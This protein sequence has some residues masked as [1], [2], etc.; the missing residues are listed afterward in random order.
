M[1]YEDFGAFMRLAVIPRQQEHP[2][3]IRLDGERTGGK[4]K[5]FGFFRY[6]G[7]EWKVDEDTHY[8][9]LELAYSAFV[10]GDDPFV[11]SETSTGKGRCLSL[12]AE[13]RKRQQSRAKYLYI[14]SN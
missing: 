10:K 7:R 6:N 13:L 8:L 9:P 2:N 3:D 1:V 14:Y 11:E 4:R 5:A 12:A